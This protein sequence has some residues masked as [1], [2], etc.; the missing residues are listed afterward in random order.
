MEYFVKSNSPPN[1]MRISAAR[2]QM[3]GG[4]LLTFTSQ[5]WEQTRAARENTSFG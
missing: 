4:G 2:H 1:P 5:S 3:A